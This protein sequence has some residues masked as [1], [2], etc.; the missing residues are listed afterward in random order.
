MCACHPA[1]RSPAVIIAAAIMCACLSACA[2]APDPW[3]AGAGT[4]EVDEIDVA[5]LAAARVSRIVATEGA[6]VHAGDT[7]VTLVLTGLPADIA[8]RQARV[9]AAEATLRDLQAGARQ[10]EIARAEVEFRSAEGDAASAQREVER[11]TP[12]AATHV[13]SQQA[14][15]AAKTLAFAAAGRR[16]AAREALQLVTAGARPERIAGAHAEVDAAKASLS[17]AR[18]AATDLVL[19][20][21]IAGTVL[22]RHVMQ[23]EVVPAGTPTMTIGDLTHPW[24]RVF[25]AARA[26]PG[27]RLGQSASAH[28]D[29]LPGQTFPGRIVSID[30]SAQFTPRVALSEEE[31][32][33]LLF[34][35]KVALDD[36]TRTL[37]PGL[38]AQV[39]IDTAAT[40]GTPR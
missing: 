8:Q 25:V 13:V 34:G 20:A 40:R 30:A 27:L 39:R 14:L 3:V 22:A 29:G 10:P 11:L 23:G 19:L 33:D 2:R 17:A 15:D 38:P 12:L 36:T 31:R 24:V 35:V 9:L 18:S 6:V 28:V 21:P 4:I 26:L 32:A 7:V 37:K 5:P 16:D 1:A